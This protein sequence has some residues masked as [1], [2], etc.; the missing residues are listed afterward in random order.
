MPYAFP[1]ANMAAVPRYVAGCNHAKSR[2]RLNL[3]IGWREGRTD[4]RTDGRMD[5][6]EWLF[7]LTCQPVHPPIHPSIHPAAPPLRSPTMTCITGILNAHKGAPKTDRLAHPSIPLKFPCGN[8]RTQA[9]DP[10]GD[11]LSKTHAITCSQK[12]SPLFHRKLA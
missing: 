5:G 2:T 11:T 9:L 7:V 6:D 1:I 8:V 4:R 12:V 10:A 3:A